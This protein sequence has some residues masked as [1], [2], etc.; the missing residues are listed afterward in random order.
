M[1]FLE[2]DLAHDLK[3]ENYEKQLDE[4]SSDTV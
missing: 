1:S 4:F 3:I 2:I